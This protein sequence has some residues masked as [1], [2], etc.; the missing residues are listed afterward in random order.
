MPVRRAP[1]AEL[2]GAA[3]AAQ[4]GED[5]AHEGVE[6]RDV[7][8]GRQGAVGRVGHEAGVAARRHGAG[9]AVEGDRGGGRR[10]LQVGQAEEV[11]VHCV[12]GHRVGDDVAA[13]ADRRGRPA[14]VDGQRLHADRV[15]ARQAEH[16]VEDAG[17][18]A[19]HRR[20][21]TGGADLGEQATEDGAPARQVAAAGHARRVEVQVGRQD[22]VD[23]VEQALNRPGER[24]RVAARRRGGGGHAAADRRCR[25]Q[26]AAEQ[27]L[28]HARQAQADGHVGQ[29]PGARSRRVAAG[30]LGGRGRAARHVD[31]DE[32][33]VDRERAVAAASTASR[34]C[35][36]RWRPRPACCRGRTRSASWW[37]SSG[38]GCSMPP[39][40]GRHRCPRPRRAVC[41]R[42][43][44]P[45][46]HRR[47]GGC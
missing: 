4:R 34:S 18:D 44:P 25:R 31:V 40:R 35:R 13:R 33:R 16:L 1:S 21:A 2:E 10:H 3:A 11:D 36:L 7:D 46:R 12:L 37:R 41:C 17:H 24:G 8:E 38:R 29:A 26:R 19:G 15:A 20:R 47:V 22:A 14:Q 28:Q 30:V 43:R 5:L 9:A 32:P 27:L 42:R 45:S 39:S 6:L 23:G